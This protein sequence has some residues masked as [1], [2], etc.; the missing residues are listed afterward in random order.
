MTTQETHEII[1]KKRK[2]PEKETI[3]EC[4]IYNNCSALVNALF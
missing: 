1:K 3:T 4:D 2:V